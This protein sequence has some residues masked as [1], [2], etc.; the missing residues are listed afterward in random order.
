MKPVTSSL[1]LSAEPTHRSLRT[2]AALWDVPLARSGIP[3]GFAAVTGRS[4]KGLPRRISDLGWAA[5]ERGG[6]PGVRF[7]R[8]SCRK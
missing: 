5:L 8:C 6:E 3:S 7:S 1:L 2:F 4:L